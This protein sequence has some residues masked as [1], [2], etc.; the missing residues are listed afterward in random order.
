MA[1]WLP[2]VAPYLPDIIRLARP[3]FT[4]TQPEEKTPEVVTEQIVELQNAVTQNAESVK[5]LA[6]EMQKTIATL[7]QSAEVIQKKLDQA[8]NLAFAAVLFALIA[9]AVAGYLLIKAS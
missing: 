1:A 9:F 7:E 2:I 8:R 5:L 4:R 6:V 3:L